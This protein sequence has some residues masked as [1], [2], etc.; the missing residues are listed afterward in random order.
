MNLF[1]LTLILGVG[2]IAFALIASK[3]SP[4]KKPTNHDQ[5]KE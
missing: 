3:K 2:V 1:L 4:P 5:T